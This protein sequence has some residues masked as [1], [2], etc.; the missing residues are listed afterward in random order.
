MLNLAYWLRRFGPSSGKASKLYG[1]I[2]TQSRDPVFY[3]DI[4]VPDTVNGRYE[5]TV[6]H[7]AL[8]LQA[9]KA[10]EGG[11]GPVG[12]ALVEVFVVDID[13]SLREMAVGDMSIPRRVKKAAAGLMDRA[14][15]YQEANTKYEQKN[16]HLN[17]V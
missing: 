5:L 13:D 7:M 4:G 16:K 9:L 17:F 8:V 2:V 10:F 1:S 15:A 12:K 3:R 6:L 14:L 11:N